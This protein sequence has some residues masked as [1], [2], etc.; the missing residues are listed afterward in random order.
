[1]ENN[2]SLLWH[3]NPIGPYLQQM[4]LRYLNNELHTVIYVFLL[5]GLC[6]L[7]VQLPWLRFLR[8]FSSVVRQMPGYNSPR[9]G[10]AR[11]VPI[12]FLCCSMY[13]LFFVVLCIVCVWMC[14][15]L[16]PP[17]VNPI[18]VNKYI[19]INTN[20]SF[21]LMESTVYIQFIRINTNILLY[22]NRTPIQFSQHVFCKISVK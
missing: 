10:T 5:L 1:V 11:T 15:V 16:L 17:G 13:C 6:I 3:I 20:L 4:M 18:A 21:L 9:R 7:T 8:A 2:S 22:V 12:T 19:N 14:T